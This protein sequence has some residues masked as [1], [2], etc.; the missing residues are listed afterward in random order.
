M[1][2][3]FVDTNI[4]VDLLADRKP[5]SNH[6]IE[7]FSMAEDGKLQLFASSHSIATTYY[8]LKKYMNDK[9]LRRIIS[10]LMDYLV[11]IPVDTDVLRKSLR[12]GV[13]DFEDAVQIFCAASVHKLDCIVTRN[14]KDYKGSALS[15][16]APDELCALL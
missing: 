9:D 4:L 11:V 12:S 6:A 5:F 3:V 10:G 16:L 8:L 13:K 14:V 2:K 1:K 15:V 7:I